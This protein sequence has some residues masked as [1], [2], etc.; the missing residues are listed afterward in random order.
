MHPYL[1]LVLAVFGGF[2][3]TLAAGSIWTQM[4]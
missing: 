1:I 2:A 4:K 3:V